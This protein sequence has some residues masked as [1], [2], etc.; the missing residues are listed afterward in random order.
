MKWSGAEQREDEV[1]VDFHTHHF[2]YFR[3]IIVECGDFPSIMSTTFYSFKSQQPRKGT[4]EEYSFHIKEFSMVPKG[5]CLK[6]ELRVGYC[7]VQSCFEQK[8]F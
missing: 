1:T 4:S 3:G 2:Q 8:P 6:L 5:K 7:H